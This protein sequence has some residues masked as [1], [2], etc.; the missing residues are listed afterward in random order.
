MQAVDIIAQA[1]GIVGMALSIASFQNRGNKG[2][3]I[4]QAASG[5]AFAVNYFLIGAVTAALLNCTNLVR[6]AVYAKNDGKL[7]RLLLV[8]GLYTVCS[9]YAF[10]FHAW[11]DTVQVVLSLLTYLTVLVGSIVMHGGDGKKIR[12]AQLFCIS[13]I[14][15]V[16]NCI[17]FTLG[18]ILCEVFAICSVLVSF[19]RFG[20]DG[21]EK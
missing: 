2:F 5:L 21:F 17:N 13:P 6:G 18:G 9:V 1:F 11:G 7:W 3:F 8:L 14:W 16:H 12:Y 4:M 15:L 19:L 10:V 20:K